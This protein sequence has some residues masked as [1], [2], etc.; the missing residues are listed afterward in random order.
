[1]VL[2]QLIWRL[3]S[4]T[5]S[6]LEFQITQLLCREFSWVWQ[7]KVQIFET[8]VVIVPSSSVKVT[9]LVDLAVKLILVFEKISQEGLGRIPETCPFELNRL[10]ED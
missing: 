9:G 1:M 10:N 8:H 6:D 2:A 7:M 3:L 5:A 4:H